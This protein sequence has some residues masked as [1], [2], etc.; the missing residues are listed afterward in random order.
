M[1]NF[2]KDKN[3]SQFIITFKE[4]PELDGRNVVF[5]KVLKGMELIRKIE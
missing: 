5:G 1:A 2:G 3:A 4:T